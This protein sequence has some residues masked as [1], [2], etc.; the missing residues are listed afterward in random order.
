[1]PASEFAKLGEAIFMPL[2]C[3]QGNLDNQ[4]QQVLFVTKEQNIV[5]PHQ[6]LMTTIFV[7]IQISMAGTTYHC[8]NVQ[9]LCH[10]KGLGPNDV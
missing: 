1:M 3:W 7:Q 2:H 4:E 9:I 6:V 8:C 10:K 5:L